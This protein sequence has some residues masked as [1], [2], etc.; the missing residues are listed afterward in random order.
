MRTIGGRCRTHEHHTTGWPCAYRT[1]ARQRPSPWV[2]LWLPSRA[3]A[4]QLMRSASSVSVFPLIAGA[5]TPSTR[6][7]TVRVR[8]RVR[9]CVCA[10]AGVWV[11]VWAWVCCVC[12]CVCARTRMP[13]GPGGGAVRWF[14]RVR[15]RLLLGLVFLP[16]LLLF[17]LGAA[18][19]HGG[20]GLRYSLAPNPQLGCPADPTLPDQPSQ[21]GPWITAWLPVARHA[22]PTP[23][24]LV[25]RAAAQALPADRRVS[26]NPPR[27]ER[28]VRPFGRPALPPLVELLISS[29]A[30][31]PEMPRA[32]SNPSSKLQPEASRREQVSTSTVSPLAKRLT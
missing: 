6:L 15:L 11:W 29:T 20:S 21:R 10:C 13:Q 3:L 16:L 32:S 23:V 4:C 17:R 28:C 14:L 2:W 5:H 30:A 27:G 7:A 19:P 8:V 9:V 22:A 31:G 26:A 1:W 12:M 18:G 25:R 24:P